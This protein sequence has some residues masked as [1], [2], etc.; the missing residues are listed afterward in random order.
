MLRQQTAGQGTLLEKNGSARMSRAFGSF[1]SGPKLL[2]ICVASVCLL[3]PVLAQQKTGSE[4]Y[5]HPVIQTAP[6]FASD[7]ELK[8][9]HGEFLVRRKGTQKWKPSSQFSEPIAIGLLDG[10]RKIYVA[11]KA[12]KPPKAIHMQDP[13]YPESERKS[14]K[15]GYV[16]L[17]VVVDDQGAVSDPI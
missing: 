16:S 9:D 10:D 14:G 6:T 7:F 15:E 12:L 5:A 3:A 2:T 1:E 4:S 11:T 17:H 13:N 8:I